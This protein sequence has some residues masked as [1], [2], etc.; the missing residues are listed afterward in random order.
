MILTRCT[1][2]DSCLRRHLRVCYSQAESPQTDTMALRTLLADR[3]VL[4]ARGNKTRNPQLRMP[5][6]GSMHHRHNQEAHDMLLWLKQAL[7]PRRP[8][9]PPAQSLLPVS[10]FHRHN[11]LCSKCSSNARH[12]DRRL[13]TSTAT[14]TD[15]LYE[16]LLRIHLLNQFLLPTNLEPHHGPTWL[17]RKLKRKGSKLYA[18][19]RS[20]ACKPASNN[21]G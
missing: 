20:N 12:E 14:A 17:H 8:V 16:H 18:W 4:L 13:A 2:A 11:K 15:P 9:L 3:E 7:S 1:L 6:L 10:T 5:W 21:T 19:K